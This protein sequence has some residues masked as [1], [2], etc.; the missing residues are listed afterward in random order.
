MYTALKF[1]LGKPLALPISFRKGEIYLSSLIAK[2]TN[3]VKLYKVKEFYSK[4]YP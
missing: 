2:L 4:I 3:F 1:W